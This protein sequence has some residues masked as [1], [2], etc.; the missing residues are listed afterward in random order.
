MDLGHIDRLGIKAQSLEEKAQ[1]QWLD[2]VGAKSD[3]QVGRTSGRKGQTP[4]IEI[5]GNRFWCNMLSTITNYGS[6]EFMMFTEKFTQD[7][8]LKFL[9]RLVRNKKQKILLVLDS[10]PVHKGKKIGR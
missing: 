9:K 6:L 4:T 8:F 3:D 7:L 2:E 5:S 1:I 10:H